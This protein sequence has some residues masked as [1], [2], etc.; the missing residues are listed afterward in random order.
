[1]HRSRIFREVRQKAVHDG[2]HLLR[3]RDSDDV[4][5]DV[6]SVVALKMNRELTQ[7]QSSTSV[8]PPGALL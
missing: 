2:G 3:L 8:L 4:V 7:S 6:I 1:M 5:S